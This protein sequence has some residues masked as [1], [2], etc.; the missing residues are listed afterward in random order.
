MKATEANAYKIVIYAKIER[1]GEM[2]MKRKW[3]KV[4]PPFSMDQKELKF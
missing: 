1:V 3:I 4:Y 2:Q